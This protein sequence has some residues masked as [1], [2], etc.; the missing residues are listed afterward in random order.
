MKTNKLV[1][2][3]FLL[4]VILISCEQ[5]SI[6]NQHKFTVS[7]VPLKRGFVTQK[8]VLPSD[9]LHIFFE[10]NFQNDTVILRDKSNILETVD[11]STRPDTGLADYRSFKTS[12]IKNKLYINVN[13]RVEAYLEKDS[14]RSNII[15]VRYFE[16]SL[17]EVI[18]LK[19]IPNYY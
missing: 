8:K 12:M 13:Q 5:V 4:V 1:Y 9:Y 10:F 6:E 15:A 18:S 14:L 2:I 11:L 16:D 7:Y 3:T 17:L 19:N